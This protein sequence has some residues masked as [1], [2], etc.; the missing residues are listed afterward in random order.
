MIDG[1]GWNDFCLFLSLNVHIKI[2]RFILVKDDYLMVGFLQIS[3]ISVT[4]GIGGSIDMDLVD[5]FVVL[6]GQVLGE[7][8]NHFTAEDVV[9]VI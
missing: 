3:N 1:L 4:K 7:R 6:E 2:H 8:T 5:P 9:Q